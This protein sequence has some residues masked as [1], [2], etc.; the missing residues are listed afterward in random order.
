MLNITG[1]S[2]GW[3]LPIDAAAAVTQSAHDECLQ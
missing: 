2:I 3:K 1:A